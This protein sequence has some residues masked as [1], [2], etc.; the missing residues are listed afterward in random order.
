MS[1]IRLRQGTLMS[2][3][4]LFQKILPDF[5]IFGVFAFFAPFWCIFD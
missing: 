3:I 2:Y 4:R 5:E 1:Y